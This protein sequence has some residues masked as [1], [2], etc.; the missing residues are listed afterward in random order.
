MPTAAEII[1]R[2]ELRPHPE[3]GHYRE[4]FR[5]QTTDANGRARLQCRI[6]GL[7]RQRELDVGGGIFVA[8]IESEI[9]R[10][11]AQLE[12][13]IPHHG[14]GALEYPAA[15]D[16]EQRVGG[17][18]RFL[19]VEHI[20]DVVER[21]AGRLQYAPEQAADLDD[22]G[23]GD[24]QVDVCDFGRLVMWRDD[25]A[26][27][28]LF[29]FGDPADMIA[30]MMGDQDIG[31]LPALALE[32]PQDGAGFRRVDRRRRLGVHIMDQITEIVV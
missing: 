1:A 25:A 16:R 26:I 13:R 9:V 19:G 31:E 4:T 8:A 30:M 14:V 23:I 17:E 6:V 20:G 27:V 18:Q 10:Q 21:V 11:R 29:E 5:D 12:K 15:A 2:L 24:A 3:G 22:F 28:F 7:D 32:R